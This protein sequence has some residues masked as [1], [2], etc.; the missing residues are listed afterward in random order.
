MEVNRLS[1]NFTWYKMLR[2]AKIILKKNKGKG[3][4][5]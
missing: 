4:D 5:F 1:L 2:I 3:L